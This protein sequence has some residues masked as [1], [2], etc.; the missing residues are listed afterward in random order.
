MNLDRLTNIT[1]ELSSSLV[2]SIVVPGGLLEWLSRPLAELLREK[3]PP[4]KGDPRQETKGEDPASAKSTAWAGPVVLLGGAPAP[5]EAIVAMVHLAGGRTAPV[6]VLPVAA[7]DP[8]QSGAESLRIFSRFGMR[9][10]ELLDGLTRELL[11]SPEFAARLAEYTAVFLSGKDVSLGLANLAGTRT[12]QVLQEFQAAGKLVAGVD[13]GAAIL[14]EKVFTADGEMLPG[15]G[16]LPGL[17][18]ETNFTQESRFGRV[19]RLLNT[20]DGAA[21]MAAGVDAGASLVLRAGEARV[22]G[23]TSVT[24]LD[25]RETGDDAHAVGALKVHV[26]AEH[27]GFNLRTRKPFA[28]VKELPPAQAAGGER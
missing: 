7:A 2:K 19:A 9:K 27:Y 4:G 5:D 20:E 28:P 26:L 16:L 21:L 3:Q 22:L 11:D 24:F 1:S 14:G 17:M 18:V 15:L 13:A 12:A 6:A 23:E 8:A 10:T 25:P